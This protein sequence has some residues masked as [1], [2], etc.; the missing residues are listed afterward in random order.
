MLAQQGMRA[1]PAQRRLAPPALAQA[2]DEARFL[3]LAAKIFAALIILRAVLTDPLLN[4]FI[5]YSGEGGSLIEKIHPATYGMLILLFVTLT[6]VRIV[7]NRV[8]ARLI[9]PLFLFIG[10]I[11]GLVILLQI[12]G[13]SVSVGYLIETY[14]AGC[15]IAFFMFAFQPEQRRMIGNA[16][17]IYI[18]VNAMLAILEKV[19]GQRLLPY[20]YAEISFRPTALTSHPLVIGL[21]NSGA[22]VFILATRWRA[23]IKGAAL[24]IVIMGTFA[25]GARTGAILSTLAVIA[26]LTLT[27]MPGRSASERATWRAILFGSILIAGPILLVIADQAG[28]LERFYGGY[29]DENAHARIDVYQVFDW[30]S[31]GDIL[32]GRDII[33]IKKMV[34]DRLNILVESSVVVFVF[35]FGLFGA[36]AF[37]G[38]LLWSLLRLAARADPRAYIAV[39]AFLMVAMSNDSLS[40]KHWYITMMFLLLIAF[41][42]D[43]PDVFGRLVRRHWGT[44]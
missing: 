13:R 21:I 27:E 3:A 43:R 12:M 24:L 35:Q 33:E 37:A 25:A 41:R 15:L 19:A 6:R 28:F 4:G 10:L 2:P 22:V 5:N 40:G 31:W 20:P 9:L 26:A 38:M 44:A 23:A 34:M 14:I 18:V 29:I 7:L 39:L 32:I 36:L 30:V 1:Y 16:I 8:E 42:D 11:F 17:L